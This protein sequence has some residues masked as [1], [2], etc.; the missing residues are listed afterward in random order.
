MR[1]IHLALAWKELHE[2]AWAV[3]AA[4][5]IALLFPL[6][7]ILYDARLGWESILGVLLLYPFVGGVFFGM[8]AA[9]GERA[10]RTAAFIAALPTEAHVLARVRLVAAIVAALIPILLLTLLGLVV[11]GEHR[12]VLV[13]GAITAAVTIHVLLFVAVFGLG[14]A[15]EIQAAIRGVL[16]LAVWGSA[17]LYVFQIWP[18]NQFVQFVRWLGPPW[19][20]FFA[21]LENSPARLSPP[22]VLIPI[23]S[24]L[25]LAIIF[26][27]H[28]GRAIQPLPDKKAWRIVVW[29][30]Q[31]LR[32]PLAAL[33]WKQAAETIPMSLAV[34]GSAIIFSLLWGWEMNKQMDIAQRSEIIL[35]LFSGTAVTVGFLLALLIGV[36]TFAPDLE[37]RVNTFWRSRPI[38]VSAWFWSKYLIGALAMLLTLGLP[39]LA[40]AYWSH[41]HHL[42][43]Q[44]N[45]EF[46]YT[47][48][49][50]GLV[51]LLAFAVAVATTCV[52]RH[53][54][55][56]SILTVGIVLLYTIAVFWQNSTTG[57]PPSNE[58]VVASF[59][60]GSLTATALGWWFA[61]RDLV[62]YQT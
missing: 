26:V 25:T 60:V 7:M 34:L 38:S 30:P 10:H 47:A 22:A 15:S 58:Y 62:A 41:D 19:E 55:Y 46:I 28:Y 2:Q 56:A 5:A 61:V 18:E 31:R 48:I 1:S 44:Q 4:A 13:L 59:G 9:A 27:I 49:S 45:K 40:S 37:P 8:R 29:M 35:A 6:A 32:W 53:T 52:V 3:L 51:W 42:P 24:M 39:A 21:I 50:W 43:S 11:L 12:H 54:L 33:A 20:W 14:A 17:A 23:A 36:G 57:H 16:V